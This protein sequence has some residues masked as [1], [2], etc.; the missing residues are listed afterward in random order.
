[1]HDDQHSWDEWYRS[2]DT[3]WSGRPNPQLVAEAAGLPP[4]TTLDAGCGEGGDALW[5][6]RHGWRVT[7]ADIAPVALERA[8]AQAKV[9]G[10][11]VEWVHADLT[12]WTPPSRYDLVTTHYLHLPGDA[13]ERALTRLAAAVAPGGTLLVVGHDHEHIARHH[14]DVADRYFSPESVAARLGDGWEIQVAETR[15]RTTT[16]PG[17][18]EVTVGDAVLRARRAD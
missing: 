15:P 8:A 12:T 6:A 9:E 2:A 13:L 11:D 7:G 14:P 17:G 10:L 1:M 18:E 5:L 3:I 4:G 16:D